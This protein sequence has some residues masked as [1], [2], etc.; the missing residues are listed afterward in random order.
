MIRNSGIHDLL[1]LPLYLR[2]T[3]MLVQVFVEYISILFALSYNLGA[4]TA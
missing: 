3:T 1:T 2:I 4:I